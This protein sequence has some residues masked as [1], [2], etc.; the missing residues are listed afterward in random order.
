MTEVPHD[1]L[2]IE[3]VNNTYPAH[4]HDEFAAHFRGLMGLW[5]ADQR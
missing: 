2:L 5:A 4:E 1:D 3:T